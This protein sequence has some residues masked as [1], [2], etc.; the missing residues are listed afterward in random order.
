MAKYSTSEISVLLTSAGLKAKVEKFDKRGFEVLSKAIELETER[1]FGVNLDA[2][3]L[4]ESIF[5]KLTA[6]GE[7]NK[8]EI[9]FNQDYI[10]TLSYY[11]G[12]NSFND[13]QSTLKRWDSLLKSI[14]PKFWKIGVIHDIKST[15][16][17]KEVLGLIS[18]ASLNGENIPISSAESNIKGVIN[19]VCLA[20]V[21]VNQYL[22]VNKDDNPFPEL[23]KS[24]AVPL[25]FHITDKDATPNP[26]EN[27]IW[28]QNFLATEK[29]V[30]LIIALIKLYQTREEVNSNEEINKKES[31]INAEN[32]G[33]IILGNS[34]VKAEYLSS[35]D[36]NITINKTSKN[37]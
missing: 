6:A 37:S 32:V 26:E 17:Q 10:D 18:A 28:R 5:D 15:K 30:L 2:R 27:M 29:E 33:T 12:Y 4:K 34:K 11:T 22:K 20:I 31:T 24:G 23:S 16:V 36:M 19:Q 7:E 13:F 8:S 25:V 14:N 3:Y 1:P 35:R 9:G 21:L